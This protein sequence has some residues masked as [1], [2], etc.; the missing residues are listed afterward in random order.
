[1]TFPFWAVTPLTLC[2][3]SGGRSWPRSAR[4]SR[5]DDR[6]NLV[7]L[8]DPQEVSRREIDEPTDRGGEDRLE[9]QHQLGRIDEEIEWQVRHADESEHGNAPEKARADLV[10]GE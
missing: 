1:M 9:R 8:A 5:S 6:E 2:A 7:E 10:G 4:E 3:K